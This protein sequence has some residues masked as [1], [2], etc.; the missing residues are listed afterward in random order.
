MESASLTGICSPLP[1][2]GVWN[3]AVS[4][5]R[6]LIASAPQGRNRRSGLRQRLHQSHFGTVHRRAAGTPHHPRPHPGDQRRELLPQAWQGERSLEGFRRTG[7]QAAFCG[8]NCPSLST[9]WRTPHS[10]PYVVQVGTITPPHWLTFSAPLTEG[11]E[12][13]EG[14]LPWCSGCPGLSLFLGGQLRAI[15][16]A[17]LGPSSIFNRPKALA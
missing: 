13:S 4:S 11:F 6:R 14:Q 12:R 17:T 9:S 7:R 15:G 2:A 3:E 10:I 16:V 8:T 1:S 5:P